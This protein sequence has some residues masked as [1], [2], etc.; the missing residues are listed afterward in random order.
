MTAAPAATATWRQAVQ[1]IA[2]LLD[3][4]NITRTQAAARLNISPTTLRR[5]LIGQRLMNTN[6]LLGLCT[7]LDADVNEVLNQAGRHAAPIPAP[8]SDQT[9]LP[10][11]ADSQ[12]GP[13][14]SRWEYLGEWSRLIEVES[15]AGWFTV[16][17]T[18]YWDGRLTASEP[19]L[20]GKPLNE[21]TP[22]DLPMLASD[23]TALVNVIRQSAV[24]DSGDGS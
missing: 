24:R 5:T 6:E 10:V 23:L 11:W 13:R 14:V 22:A 16:A 15:P 8:T 18:Q 1:L 4:S 12:L 2:N 20:D 7:L 17:C 9:P 3:Q 19:I 21:L